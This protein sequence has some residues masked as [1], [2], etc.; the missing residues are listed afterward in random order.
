[1]SH[2]E[3]TAQNSRIPNRGGSRLPGLEREF[4]AEWFGWEKM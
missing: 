2:W 4:S 1:M 3:N